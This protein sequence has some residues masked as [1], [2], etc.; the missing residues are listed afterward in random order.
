M[1][2]SDVQ[3]GDESTNKLLE[4]FVDDVRRSLRRTAIG[5]VSSRAETS[6]LPQRLSSIELGQR[7]RVRYLLALSIAGTAEH[8]RV[9]A[10]LIDTSTGYLSDDWTLSSSIS[11]L[12][13]LNATLIRNVA[14]R[15]TND[16]NKVQIVSNE[17]A[18]AYNRYLEG[19]ALLRDGSSED[20]L[21]RAQTSF[22]SILEQWPRYALA[23]R[24]CAR[25]T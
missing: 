24:R 13:A 3:T 20:Q 17:P 18:E 22:E 14:G 6:S 8:L 11:G 4:A 25:F 10:E 21:A 9:L 5:K 16:V 15:F 7:L 12:S 2:A 23:K 1:V 19:R